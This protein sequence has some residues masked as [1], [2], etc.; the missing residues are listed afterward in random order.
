[1]SPRR[2]AAAAKLRP[3]QNFAPVFAAL[4]DEMRLKL[5]AALCVGGAMSITQLTSGTEIS[6]QA[7][8]KHLGVLAAAGLVRDVKVGRERLW[9]FE[10]TQLDEARRT[11]EF[12][13]RQW[14]HALA[15]LKFVVES[16]PI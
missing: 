16:N 5:V 2:K 3:L 10:P 14:E 15:K 1:M 12:I 9:E 6:R 8:T 4:G 13:G 7:I 11:L